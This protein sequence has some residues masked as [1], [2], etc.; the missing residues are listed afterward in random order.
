MS[1]RD[2][3]EL[4]SELTGEQFFDTYIKDNDVFSQMPLECWDFVEENSDEVYQEALSIYGDEWAVAEAAVRCV[5]S[6]HGLNGESW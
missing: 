3:V 6:R 1:K 4:P 5:L 2:E